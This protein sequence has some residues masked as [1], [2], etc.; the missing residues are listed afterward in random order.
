MEFGSPVQRGLLFNEPQR[1]TAEKRDRLLCARVERTVRVFL[2]DG[3]S[4]NE[5]A[6]WRYSAPIPLLFT[7]EV[8]LVMLWKS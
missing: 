8:R 4:V 2:G 7:Q 5:Q 1:P 3:Y 6:L